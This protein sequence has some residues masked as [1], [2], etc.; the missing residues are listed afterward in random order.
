MANVKLE[1]LSE[2]VLETTTLLYGEKTPYTALADAGKIPLSL[3]DARYLQ[4]AGDAMVGNLDMDDNLVQNIECATFN[5]AP[6]APCGIGEM[7][8]NPDDGTINVGLLGGTVVLQVG[9]E[10]N[11]YVVQKTGS[12]IPNGKAVIVIGVSGDRLEVALTDLTN[13]A[14]SATSGLTTEAID[15]NQQGYMTT[16]GLVRGLDTSMWAEGAFIWADGVTPGELT[17]TRPVAPLRGVFIGFVVR[18]H[19][20]L[21][22]IW[23]F[24]FNIPRL[25]FLSDVFAAAP[26]DG[27]YLRWSSANSRWQLS[28]T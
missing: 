16:F 23:V 9:Q 8:W 28:A 27:D 22:S 19:A 2:L 21:G 7:Q 20:T 17:D 25:Q 11:A 15:N 1:D 18:S 5:L 24:P 3:M 10:V 4:V 6:A 13:P 14:R 12:T 26:S